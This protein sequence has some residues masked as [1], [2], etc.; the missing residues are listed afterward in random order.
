MTKLL[1]QAFSEIQR[2]P[3]D[4]QDTIATRI[5][6]DLKDEHVWTARFEATTDEQWDRLAEA[7]RKEIAASEPF[8]FDDVFRTAQ[9]SPPGPLS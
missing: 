2:L 6:A 1:Q 3:P 7:A 9:T 5:L 8:A 4:K